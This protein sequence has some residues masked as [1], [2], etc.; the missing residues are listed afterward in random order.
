LKTLLFTLLLVTSLFSANAK[1]SA[2]FLNAENN[3]ATA[4]EKAKQ[5]NKILVMVIVKEHCRWCDRLVKRTLADE[6]VKKPLEDFVMLVV[7]RND[8]FPNQFKEDIFPSVFYV[9]PKSEKSIYSNVGFVGTKCFL[10]DLNS[11]LSTFHTLFEN[12]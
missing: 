10:N 8:V 11:S 4:I 7:D 2:Q 5:E 1:E 6:K 12:K 3:Y 9:D